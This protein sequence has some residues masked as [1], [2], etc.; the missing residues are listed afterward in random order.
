MSQPQKTL[1]FRGEN[2]VYG[3]EDFREFLEIPRKIQLKKSRFFEDPRKK[4]IEGNP[5]KISNFEVRMRVTL[6][7][8]RVK[9]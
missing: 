5:Q 7:R 8:L 2:E 3:F 4:V 1:K 9:F 6:L